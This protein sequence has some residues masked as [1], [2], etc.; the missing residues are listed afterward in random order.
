MPNWKGFGW[1]QPRMNRDNF[2]PSAW[3]VC[4]HQSPLIKDEHE[5]QLS[6]NRAVRVQNF[7]VSNGRGGS[8]QRTLFPNLEVTSSNFGLERGYL[9]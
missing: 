6:K 7:R 8:L 9:D 5:V 2:S 1:K 4:G 3:R